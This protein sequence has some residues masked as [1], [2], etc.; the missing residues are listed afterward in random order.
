MA[1]KKPTIYLIEDDLPTIDVYQTVFEMAGF[2][3]EF[4]TLGEQVLAKIKENL[5][6]KKPQPDILLI[7]LILPDM[8]GTDIL[9]EMKKNPETSKI[10]C[11][12]LTNYSDKQLRALGIKKGAERYL[13]K[14]DFVPQELVKIVKEEI[15]KAKKA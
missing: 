15:K 14:T 8:L 4:F 12:V 6:K 1:K 11:I 9:D 3:V 5:R 2:K 7:D 10:P 13:L